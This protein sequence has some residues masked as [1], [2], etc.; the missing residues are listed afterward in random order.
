M[1]IDKICE[2]C[3]RLFQG[4]NAKNSSTICRSCVQ[5][6]ANEKRKATMM[7]KYG[8]ENI[9]HLPDAQDRIK[10]SMKKKYGENVNSVM[11]VPEIKNRIIGTMKERYGV[12]FYVQSQDYID[13]SHFKVSNKNKEVLSWI[14]SLGFTCKTEFPLEI[15]SYDILIEKLNILIEINP[16]YTHSVLGNHWNK[17]GLDPYYHLDKTELAEKYGYQ[18]IH[19]YDWDDWKRCISDI[20]YRYY[21]NIPNS[22]TIFERDKYDMTCFVDRTRRTILNPP[23]LWYSKNASRI[24]QN[25]WMKLSEKEK[26]GYLPIYDSGTIELQ[27]KYTDDEDEVYVINKSRDIKLLEH[28]ILTDKPIQKSKSKIRICEFCGKEFIPQSNRQRYCKGPHVRQ[29]PVCGKDYVEDNVENLKRPPV[30]CCYECRK[31]RREQTSLELY[32]RKDAGNSKQAREKARETCRRKYGYESPL[33]SPEIQSKTKKTLIEK[34]GVDNIRKLQTRTRQE[35]YSNKN[36]DIVSNTE[37]SELKHHVVRKL[38]QAKIPYELE[39]R[40]ENRSYDICISDQHVLIEIDPTYTNNSFGNHWDENGLDKYYHRDKSVIAEEH[41]YR[42]IHVFDWDD[43]DKIIESLCVKQ[44]L[45]ARKC[46]IYKIKNDVCDDFLSKYHFQ[47]TCRGQLL[48]LGLVHQGELVQVMTF[49]KAR[50]SKKHDVELLR[51]CTKPKYRVIGGA[52]KLFKFATEYYGLHNI[53]SYCDRSKFSGQVYENLGMAL[54]RKTPPQEIWSNGD[55]KITANLLRQRG[56]DQLF[57]T[58]Y[59]KGT[60]NEELMLEHGWLPVYDCGQNVYEY[61]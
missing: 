14:E 49:G 53:I 59:G 10:A 28:C 39:I 5:K 19:I 42:C 58:Q 40:I 1:L 34:Y 21:H 25:D 20:I 16:T 57:H 47:G 13:H 31:V 4:S 15:K 45:Y 48:C 37:S 61:V 12:P 38:E 2:Q 43:M 18:C 52:S 36:E 56:F 35:S 60:S 50:Y 30:A 32:G 24:S 44:N 11:D 7:K 46:S 55:H 8:V 33:E 22:G 9:M 54:V 27:S 23:R 17:N 51:L 3:G 26:E 6:N 41:G 29:C